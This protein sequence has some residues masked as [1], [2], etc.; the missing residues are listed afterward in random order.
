M[1]GILANQASWQYS[2]VCGST[3]VAYTAYTLGVTQWRTKFR[4]QMIA[5]ENQASAKVSRPMRKGV[6]CSRLGKRLACWPGL[7]PSWA[8]AF[9]HYQ[10]CIRGVSVMKAGSSSERTDSFFLGWLDGV[11]FFS[12]GVALLK[13][14]KPK[15]K[16]RFLRILFQS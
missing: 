13:I 3:I 7:R 1:S 6:W 2:A 12:P 14:P 9:A 8:P 5:L 4:K 16:L 11:N 15:S 10:K